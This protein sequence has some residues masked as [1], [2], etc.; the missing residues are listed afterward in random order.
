MV[1]L[2]SNEVDVSEAQTAS[3]I[4]AEIAIW[5]AQTP[6]VAEKRRL[7]IVSAYAI[8]TSYGYDSS[9]TDFEQALAHGLIDAGGNEEA[10]TG[11][12]EQVNDLWTLRKI[13]AL[14]YFDEDLK[15]Y[16][17]RVKK[18]KKWLEPRVFIKSILEL[19]EVS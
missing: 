6:G 3:R 2:Y 10:A 15:P 16:G 7:E 14:Y 9:E 18:N 8:A 4:M 17:I 13:F 1:D 12:A 19:R 5:A 11:L